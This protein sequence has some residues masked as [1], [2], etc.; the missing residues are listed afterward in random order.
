MSDRPIPPFSTDQSAF[1]TRGD[2]IRVLGQGGSATAFPL[3]DLEA[4]VDHVTSSL[5]AGRASPDT[6]R[7]LAWDDP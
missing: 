5:E 2:T 7:P 1:L 4:F 6:D 3:S